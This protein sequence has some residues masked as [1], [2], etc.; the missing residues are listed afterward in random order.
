MAKRSYKQ[1]CAMARALDVVGSRWTLLLV[2]ELL[3]GP[4]RFTDLLTWMPSIG[5]NLLTDRLK[6]LEGHGIVAKRTLPPPAGSAVYELTEVGR[7]LEPVVLAL[8]RWGIRML[9]RPEDPQLFSARWSILEMKALFIPE[10]AV[11]LNEAY[12]FH[13]SGEV[14]HVVIDGG[15]V[16][17]GQGPAQDPVVTLTADQDAFLD[18]CWGALD[19]DDAESAGVQI[20]GDRDALLRAMKIFGLPPEV[21]C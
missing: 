2:R 13:V 21:H 17:P 1:Y 5:T 9:G 16:H 11:G 15:S 18:L 20:D 19:P 4:K 14:F 3:T 7:A 6:E 10:L 8:A 12:E